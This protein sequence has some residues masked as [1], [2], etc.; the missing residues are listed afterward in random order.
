MSFSLLKKQ[1]KLPVVVLVDNAS[2]CVIHD[3]SIR[4]EG[5]WLVRRIRLHI[6]KHSSPAQNKPQQRL[7]SIT[8]DASVGDHIKFYVLGNG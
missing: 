2:F 6:H 3:L 5:H 8:T 4:P 7:Y 1:T